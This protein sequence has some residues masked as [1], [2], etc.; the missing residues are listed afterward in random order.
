MPIKILL[1]KVLIH[2]SMSNSVRM[3]VFRKLSMHDAYWLLLIITY[4]LKFFKT[5]NAAKLEFTRGSNRSL[6]TFLKESK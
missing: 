6:L 3:L 1:R 2:E 5:H 4:K